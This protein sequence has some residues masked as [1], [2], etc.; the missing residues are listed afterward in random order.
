MSK[1]K[2]DKATYKPYGQGQAYLIPPSA[3]ELVPE[4]RLVRLV[5]EVI[6][7]MGLERPLR[8]YQA[9]GGASR[10]RPVMMAKPFVYG[11]MTKAFSI[12]MPAKAA[13]ENVTFMRLSGNQRPDFRTLNDFRGKVPKEVMEEIFVTAVKMP[14]AKGYIKLE[15]CFIDGTKIESASGRY[16]FVWKKA[17]ETNDRKPDE[18]L[19]GTYGWRKREGKAGT[20]STGKRTWKK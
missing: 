13:R 8:K 7:G 10:Y 17:V 4:N 18:K 14:K 12:R 20:G 15:N 16:A 9:G 6:D 11:Y 19:R 2:S 5:G 1:G 3:D